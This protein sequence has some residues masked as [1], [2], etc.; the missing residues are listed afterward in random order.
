MRIINTLAHA[1]LFL[2]KDCF[3]H[4][5]KYKQNRKQNSFRQMI[6]EFKTTGIKNQK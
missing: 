2:E 3:I 6:E 1:S 5:G 4:Y